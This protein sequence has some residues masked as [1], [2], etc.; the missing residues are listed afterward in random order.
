VNTITNAQSNRLTFQIILIVN[1]SM[2]QYNIYEY[3]HRD[4]YCGN[5]HRRVG[6]CRDTG[7]GLSTG[8]SA[9]VSG[10]EWVG[11]WTRWRLQRHRNGVEHGHLGTRVGVGVGGG[12]DAL[13]VAETGMG[14]DLGLRCV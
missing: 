13:A 1:I 8:T 12:V 11:A 4:T 14:S 3:V 5:S 10:L 6:G 9:H 7:T 2:S